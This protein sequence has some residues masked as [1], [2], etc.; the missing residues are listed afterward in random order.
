MNR[1]LKTAKQKLFEAMTLI[2]SESTKSSGDRK[3]ELFYRASDIQEIIS[4]IDR[5]LILDEK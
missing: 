2:E 1:R 4:A 5:I 3:N